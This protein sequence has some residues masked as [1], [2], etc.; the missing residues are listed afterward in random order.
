[1]P[2]PLK[3]HQ[4]LNQAPRSPHGKH[5][6]SGAPAHRHS[7]D[8]ADHSAGRTVTIS[9]TAWGA[10]VNTFFTIDEPK[11][12][13]V[14][15]AGIRTG[16]MIGHRLWWVIREAG[17]LWLCSLVHKRLWKIAETIYGDTQSY[18][19]KNLG[20]FRSTGIPGG[21]YAFSC[22]ELLAPE[23]MDISRDMRDYKEFEAAFKRFVEEHKDR[24]EVIFQVSALRVSVLIW[25][26]L[27][28]AIALACGTIKMWGDVVEHQRGYRAEFAK[29]NSLDLIHTFDEDTDAQALYDELCSR[30]GTAPSPDSPVPHHCPL[31]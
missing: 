3:F 11:P 27:R 26:P 28:H 20:F 12:P 30:Y 9:A 10:A 6:R 1:M 31:P 22:K 5:R 16:E 23:I 29:L 21:T 24:P 17:E 4:T 13:A 2:K 18:I 25:N 8:R 14:A 19:E 7:P 15:H